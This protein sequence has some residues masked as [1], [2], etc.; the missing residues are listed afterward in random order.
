MAVIQPYEE[1]FAPQGGLAAQASSEAFGAGVGAAVQNVGGATLQL[2]DA[3]AKAENEADV[4]AVH[5]E[6]ARK[7]AEWQQRLTDMENETQPGD[8][9]FVPRVMQGI[10]SDLEKAGERFKTRAGQDMFTR[11]SANMT[12]MF[13]QEAISIQS[14]LNGEFAK[15]QFKD[16]SSSLS[17]IA[18]QDH[19]Q[20]QSLLNQGLAAINDPEG[21]FGK[22][23]EPVRE[24][25]R[26][27][28][29]DTIQYAAGIGFARRF[30]NAV[31]GDVPQ[32][33]RS[34]VQQAVANP[35]APGEIPNLGASD[36][37]PYQPQDIRSRA[38]MISRP[39]PY[40]RTFEAAARLYNIDPRELKLRAVV[41]SG[42]NPTAVSN[43]NAGGIMQMTPE[44]AARLGVNRNN[45]TEAIF[46]AARLI[47]ELRTKANG[48]MSV[49]DEMYYG[50][51]NRAQ[52]GPN[53][54][55]YA[56]N[57]AGLRQAVGLGSPVSPEAF[58]A[59]AASQAGASQGWRK[60]STGIGFIDSLPSNMFF[61]VLT[62]AEQSKRAYES[63][64]ERSRL[65]REREEQ[66]ARD[67]VGNGFLARI[68]D[69][70]PENGGR[71][72]ER[73]ILSNPI[74]TTAQKQH[75][76]DYMRVRAR[77]LA[78]NGESR[79]N[80]AAVRDLVLRINAPD[81]NPNK[82]TTTEPL[83]DALRN[84]R[85]S[86]P[87]FLGL[88]NE[89]DNVPKNGIRLSSE[90]KNAL[91]NAN[92]FFTNH[93]FT[94][95]MP[96][97]GTEAFYQ[98]RLNMYEQIER[99]REE[100]KDPRAL[101]DP[102]SPDFLMSAARLNHYLGF[103]GL[104]LDQ[105]AAAV[106]NGQPPILQMAP[107]AASQALPRVRT[108]EDFNKLPKGARYVDPQGNTRVKQ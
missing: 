51:E 60:P 49:V 71:L 68:I 15:N 56:A 39:S 47:A 69:P 59:S 100:K 81:E 29:R 89:L 87:E 108:D 6:M 38:D 76:V 77:E 35:P 53:T 65:E 85:I 12:S 21:R 74:L 101:F 92:R 17:S 73:E 30:P 62:E 79:S 9:T 23:P 18:A 36:V 5:V 107:P 75:W 93:P 33:L 4:T 28:L 88:R 11:M 24:A 64:S 82:I 72:T 103:G 55:Q 37:R 50:G 25:L 84:G 99:Y 58:A 104:G 16:L 27:D 63:Q 1:R 95:A 98:F 91:S 90:I 40:D 41:E 97:K 32:E 43:K 67:A 34:V 102:Q 13:G 44:T 45:P 26:R 20:V 80:P 83:L 66:N 105:G 48:D 8:T 3:L 10:Q 7:R 14:K 42:L 52:W 61:Q 57:L 19:T 86:T 96:G 94:V 70:R 46:G 2:A 31:L 106:R 78:S 54:R 22:V